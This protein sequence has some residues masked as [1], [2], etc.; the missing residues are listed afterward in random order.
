MAENNKDGVLFE[1]IRYLKS[2][3]QHLRLMQ[4]EA[5]MRGMASIVNMLGSLKWMLKICQRDHK[6]CEIFFEYSY[7]F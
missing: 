6:H 2:Q 7:W 4:L 3:W 5:H 1:E